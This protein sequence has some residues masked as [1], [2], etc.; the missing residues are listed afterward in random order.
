[1]NQLN[2]KRSIVEQVISRAQPQK[3]D[4]GALNLKAFKSYKMD[5]EVKMKLTCSF[6]FRAA[7]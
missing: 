2:E 1:M 5:F 7:K 3:E 4:S 6:Q